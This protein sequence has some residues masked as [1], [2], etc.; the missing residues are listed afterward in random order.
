M[1]KIIITTAFLG[2]GALVVKDVL[3]PVS[4]GA[5]GI[6]FRTAYAPV[7]ETDVLFNIWYPATAGGR[8]IT[9]GGNGVFYGTNAGV[10]APR[11][12]GRFPLVLSLTGQA[13]TRASLVG[14]PLD[15]LRQA[16]LSCCLTIPERRLEMPLRRRLFASGNGP[17]I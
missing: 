4:L 17:P 10:N 3:T 2:F 14:L 5:A 12:S 13:G 1:F 6:A 9:V 16:M 8:E 7:R 11:L 15:W